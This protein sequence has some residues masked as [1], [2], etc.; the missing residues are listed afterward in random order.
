MAHQLDGKV[1]VSGQIH[2]ADVA[3]IKALGVTMIVNNRPDGE[4]AG[5][6]LGADIEDAAQAAGIEYRSVPIIR[7]IGPSDIEAMRDAF[8]SCADGKVLV[9]CRSG[10]RSTLVWALA[11]NEQGMARE[12]I[13][14]AAA[15]AG[16][17]LTPIAHLF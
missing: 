4:D 6:P 2:P 14:K 17:D 5:Q 11:R 15:G 12:E 9:F 7:G 3:E 13:E 8:D 1:L 10:T 16:V